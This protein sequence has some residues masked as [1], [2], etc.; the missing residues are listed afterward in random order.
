MIL[1]DYLISKGVPSDLD[2]LSTHTTIEDIESASINSIEIS[3]SCIVIECEGKIGV[4]LD[5]DNHEPEAAFY[6]SFPFTM[7]GELEFVNGKLEMVDMEEFEVDTS[8]FYE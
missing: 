7:K 3:N 1:Y 2:E 6:M 8:E 4:Q 5:Y